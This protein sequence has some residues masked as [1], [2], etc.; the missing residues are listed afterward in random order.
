[1][2]RQQAVEDAVLGAG[3]VEARPLFYRGRKIGEYTRRHRATDLYLLKRADAA[4]DHAARR[5][6][7]RREAQLRE[8]TQ[9][10]AKEDFEARVAAE[11]EKEV[12]RRISE[13]SRSPRHEAAPRDGEI[14]NASSDIAPAPCD[15][16]LAR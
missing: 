8:E 5:E 7:Q 6:E 2:R 14:A 13:M 1:M 11:V 3:H 4:A 9:R 15:I 12:A 16:A 10:A